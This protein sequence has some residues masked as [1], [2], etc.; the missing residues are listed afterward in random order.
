MRDNHDDDCRWWK[1]WHECSCGFLEEEIESGNCLEIIP[2]TFVICGE[3]GNFCSRDCWDSNK[4]T[5]KQKE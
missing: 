3:E 1:D 4:P 5:K 2:G